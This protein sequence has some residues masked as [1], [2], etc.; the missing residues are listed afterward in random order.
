VFLSIGT[1]V[2][3]VSLAMLC[4]HPTPH[5]AVALLVCAVGSTGLATAAIG[6]NTLDVAGEYSGILIG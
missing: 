1:V 2:P 5:Q 3:A 4:R 6:P